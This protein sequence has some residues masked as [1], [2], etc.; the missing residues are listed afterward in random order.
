MAI[1]VSSLS[2]SSGIN[3][4]A[5]GGTDVSGAP[6][7]PFRGLLQSLADR[8]IE[9]GDAYT[10]RLLGPNGRLL[11]AYEPARGGNAEAFRGAC[12]VDPYAPTKVVAA[13]DHVERHQMPLR[14]QA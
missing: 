7:H 2:K 5:L 14:H 8:C 12:L 10:L 6:L 3:L 9:Q 4:S 1:P 13:S 11:V